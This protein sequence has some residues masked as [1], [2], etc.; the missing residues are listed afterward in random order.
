MFVLVLASELVF[1]IPV[2]LEGFVAVSVLLLAS[3][4]IPVVLTACFR[5]TVQTPCLDG[6][7]CPVTIFGA[8]KT[9]P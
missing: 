1:A 4:P 5:A 7:T 6:G 2:V 8:S 9:P 3:D